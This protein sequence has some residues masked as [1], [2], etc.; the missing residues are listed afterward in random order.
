MQKVKVTV[1]RMLAFALVL[2][3]VLAYAPGLVFAEDTMSEEFKAYLNEDGKFV[4]YSVVPKSEDDVMFFFWENE[5]IWET[6][7]D[8]SFEE[9]SEDYMSCV[10][11][12]WA[13]EESHTVEIEYIYDEEAIAV[14][15]DAVEKIPLGE[16]NEQ[17][18]QYDIFI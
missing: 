6:Y 3:M 7:P 11:T 12:D 4:M 8:L 16:Y 5:Y 18:D 17:F 1:K 14:V 9:F 2:V 15:E 10:I 13:L